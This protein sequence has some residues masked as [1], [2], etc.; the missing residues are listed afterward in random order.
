MGKE[1]Q[2]GELTGGKENYSKKVDFDKFYT[3]EDVSKLCLSNIDLESFDLVIEPSAGGGSFYNNINHPNKVGLDIEPTHPSILKLDWLTYLIDQEYQK[4]LIVGNP[5]F[6]IRNKLSQE[7]I[8][9]ACSFNNTHTVA[10]ILPEVYK[11]HT[12]QKAIPTHFRIKTIIDLPVDSFNIE[13][14][15]Y[16]I[17]SIFM[18]IEKSEGEDL[19][20]DP[21][22]YKETDHWT[23]GTDKDYDFFVMGAAPK[24]TKDMPE[25]NNRGYYIKVKPH[26]SAEEV[27]QYFN[28]IEWKGYSS[29]N[30]GV[31]WLTKPEIVKQ[32]KDSI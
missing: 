24:T 19:R 23:Y 18:I 6:G 32:Y 29:A 30:G 17:P 21:S 26:I 4:V 22:K 15:P 10:F 31:S 14:T 3:N 8:K 13:G 9:H 25:P 2:K 1:I 7:F 12:L 16:S 28:T 20:F 27:R 11:K 5:P